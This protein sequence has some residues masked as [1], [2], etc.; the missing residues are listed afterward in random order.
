MNEIK[1]IFCEVES[2]RIEDRT[3]HLILMVLLLLLVLLPIYKKL[4]TLLN[5]RIFH[6]RL[7]FFRKRF[8]IIPSYV[9]GTSK[10]YRTYLGIPYVGRY[11]SDLSTCKKSNLIV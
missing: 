6:R 7:K 10:V 8:E 5:K 1:P 9:E 11:L 2:D 4:G 3:K